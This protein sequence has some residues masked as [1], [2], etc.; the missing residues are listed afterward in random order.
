MYGGNIGGYVNYRRLI[1]LRFESVS[2]GR[3]RHHLRSDISSDKTIPE[4]E[5]KENSDLEILR[6]QETILDILLTDQESWRLKQ[7]NWVKEAQLTHR[8]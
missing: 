8:D 5:T 2:R 3:R 1:N 4:E 7:T 6:G